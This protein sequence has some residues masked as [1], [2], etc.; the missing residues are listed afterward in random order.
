MALFGGKKYLE[1]FVVEVYDK[2][3]KPKKRSVYI[4]EYYEFGN[5]KIAFR[6][7]IF[8]CIVIGM[9]IAA[10]I[11]AG[12][13]AF[14]NN[15]YYVLVPFMLEL[16]ALFIFGYAVVELLCYRRRIKSN[17]VKRTV[18]RIKPSVI[19][20]SVAA[21]VTVIGDACYMLFDPAFTNLYAELTFFVCNLFIFGAAQYA[22]CVMPAL[23]L[24]KT[25]NPDK[26]RIQKQ[27]DDQKELDLLLEKEKLERM[28]AQSRAANEAYK[29]HKKH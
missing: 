22:R 11:T 9:L 21:A 2:D 14:A 4:G 20:L 17:D 5:Y 23:A 7:K 6:A 16:L 10:F 29:K 3:G 15:V 12:V 19:F 8:L 28:R 13:F 25:D 24:R 18:G 27:R 26:A 1:D